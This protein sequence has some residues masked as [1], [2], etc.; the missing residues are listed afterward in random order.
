MKTIFVLGSNS[1]SG[2]NFVDIALSEDYRVIGVSRS[3]E[4]HDTFLKYKKN[5]N[6]NKCFNF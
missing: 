5:K 3:Q 6:Y 1:F 2:S 4:P